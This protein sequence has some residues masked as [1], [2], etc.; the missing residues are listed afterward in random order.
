MKTNFF[1]RTVGLVCLL[2]VAVFLT[3]VSAIGVRT[4]NAQGSDFDCEYGI[5]DKSDPFLSGIYGATEIVTYSE[6]EATAAN[7]PSGF[8]GEV[9]EVLSTATNR[10]I[11][12][13]FSGQK[14]PTV[15]IESI[16]F[17]VYVGDDGISD[18]YPEVRI[19]K[20]NE[21]GSW[22]MRNN[23]TAK[24]DSWQDIVLQDGNGTFFQN[25]SG[26]TSFKD[27]SKDG[28]L[29]KFELS[30]RHNG[31]KDKPFYIDSVK[32]KLIENDGV[33]PVITYS[34]E[35]VIV[36]AQGQRLD[37]SVSATDEV[38]GEVAVEYVWSD[39]SKIDEDGNPMIGE[40]TLTFV[41][42]DF[43]GNT[44]TKQVKIT[45][46]EPD[47]T[48]PVLEIPC[49]T[50]Y[51]KIG[52][53]VL[54]TFTATD[55][56][57]GQV[58]VVQAWSE[59]A[60]DSRGRLLEGVHV[61]T[62]TATDLSGNQTVKS[63]TFIVTENGDISDVVIDEEELTKDQE[64]DSEESTSESSS[65]EE[66]ESKPESSSEEESESKPE[67][68]SEEESESKTESVLESTDD[69]SS[70]SQSQSVNNQNST[71]SGCFGAIG[72]MFGLPLLLLLGITLLKRKI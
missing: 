59:G 60:L 70:E 35:D 22:V 50:V 54:F 64:S 16:T 49:D 67:S 47:T 8:T 44:A 52:A 28:Y 48:P 6:E 13:D 38:E 18:G 9:L 39:P 62:L 42:K 25:G 7:I 66:S 71:Q 34:G 10:G 51:A 46:I 3:S 36:I 5:G 30:V 63:I 58:D 32:L 33:A 61:L 57:N 43:F 12:L 15:L 24:T 4:G 69:G 37:F 1:K 2:V 53:R 19:P 45:V 20:P 56:V 41:A 14:I 17:R 72:E 68:S 31:S 65:E 11:T 40:H 27:I 26:L 55:D 23:F 21:S 29:H